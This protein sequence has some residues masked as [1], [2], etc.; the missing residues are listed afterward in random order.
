[1]INTA[2]K[3]DSPRE[4]AESAILVSPRLKSTSAS[5]SSPVSGLTGWPVLGSSLV[6]FGVTAASAWL[7]G[8]LMHHLGDQSFSTAM[9][10][11]ALCIVA[12]AT[13]GLMHWKYPKKAVFLATL[14]VTVALAAIALYQAMVVA[15]FP[16][17][18]L[19]WAESDFVNDIIKLRLGYPFYT[20]P[21]DNNS[22]PYMPGA[23]WLTWALATI[24]GGW[25]TVPAY[26]VIQLL[27]TCAA[28]AL[29]ALCCLRIVQINAGIQVLANPRLWYGFWT[30]SL[31]LF[32]TN[33][34]TN[35]VIPF[36]HGD[37]LAQLICVVA[38]LVLLEYIRTRSRILLIL[39]AVIPAAGYCVKQSLAIWLPLYCVFLLVFEQP[40][41]WWRIA[42]VGTV[43]LLLMAAATFAF[44][45]LWG[46]PFLFWTLIELTHH[47]V[48]LYNVLEHF[49]ESSIFLAAGVMGGLIALAGDNT[50]V[51]LGAFFVWAGLLATEIYVGG[52][53]V[54]THHMG[55]G[56]TIAGIWLL[57]AFALLWNSRHP[58]SDPSC[59][60]S[61]LKA[62]GFA[63]AIGFV[64]VEAGF[65]RL[66]VSPFTPEHYRYVHDISNEFADGPSADTLL[67]FGSWIYLRDGAIMKDR[68]GPAGEL[69]SGNLADYTDFFTRIRQRRYRKILVRNLEQPSFWYDDELIKPSAGVRSVLLANYHVVRKIPAVPE[70]WMRRYQ[71]E[72]GAL[73]STISVLEP[74][75]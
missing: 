47:K 45:W 18:L 40:C 16:A 70:P 32:A 68:S 34:Y 3:K 14:G 63:T 57:S 54:M 52:V 64:F 30:L 7:I 21:V 31:F 41:K 23:Q 15:T 56:S 61:L 25:H 27:Y 11:A 51:L 5:I 6:A 50:R 24:F 58:H 17:D 20:P 38:F 4:G 49:Q 73:F 62:A 44:Y 48:H 72:S 39:M 8:S 9:L 71:H 60:K 13:P 42:K 67:D 22:Y 26:R 36:L 12:F 1:M 59:A 29:G 55:P 53:H 46:R 33:P 43:S 2:S 37:S 65:V 10:I 69:R 75:P 19:G 28:A 35:S 66:P 74:N